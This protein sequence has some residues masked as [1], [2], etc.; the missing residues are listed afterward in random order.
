MFQSSALIG[1]DD[2]DT[3][4]VEELEVSNIKCASFSNECLGN[5]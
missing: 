2:L 5:Q 3:S 1:A 4:S